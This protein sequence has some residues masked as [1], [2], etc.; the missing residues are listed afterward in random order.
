ML[1][2]CKMVNWG[3]KY[4]EYSRLESEK[5]GMIMC[6]RDTERVCSNDCAAWEFRDPQKIHCLALPCV[7]A[8]ADLSK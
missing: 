8:I 3:S 5:L 1:K 4:P 6:W 7:S 2:K